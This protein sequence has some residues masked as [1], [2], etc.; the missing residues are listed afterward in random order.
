VLKHIE[1]KKD[2]VNARLARISGRVS[3]DCKPWLQNAVEGHKPVPV[4]VLP[5]A[6]T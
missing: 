1:I 2:F 3:V 4:A 6:T 5:Q